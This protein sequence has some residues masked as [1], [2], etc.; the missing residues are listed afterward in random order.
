LDQDAVSAGEAELRIDIATGQRGGLLGRFRISAT[1]DDVEWADPRRESTMLMEKL[2]RHDP[3]DYWG[4]LSL[5]NAYARQSP[6]DWE[7]AVRFATV[8]VAL[9]PTNPRARL[10]RAKI[11][12]SSSALEKGNLI[13][14]IADA[15][16]ARDLGADERDLSR[17]GLQI[18]QVGESAFKNDQQA[19][20]IKLFRAAVKL[21]P[22]EV[23]PLL[24]LAW[25][26][27]DIDEV[28]QRNP[29]D[30]IKFA[31]MALELAPDNYYAK[32]CLGTAYYRD[33]NSAE[34]D[35]VLLEAF[36]GIG[37]KSDGGLRFHMAMVKESLG[38]HK[39]A[40]NLFRDAENRM[41]EKRPDDV[42][43][44]KLRAEAASVLGIDE[45]IPVEESSGGEEER[46]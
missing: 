20:A 4:N 46:S 38:D 34:A 26:L 32:W 8:A 10:A 1:T 44:K 41:A 29:Q 25:A 3:S 35:E 6:P 5:A 45:P 27:V 11:L 40:I 28:A 18:K 36:D 30:A 12:C 37:E 7:K 42:W 2:N 13:E 14:G 24:S 17:L 21:A 31:Q 16:R 33:G 22:R 9:E 43:L 19:F 39:S 23:G 15:V